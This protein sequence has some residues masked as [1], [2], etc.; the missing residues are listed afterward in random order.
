M[1][2][3]DF[4]VEDSSLDAEKLADAFFGVIKHLAQLS[5]GVGFVF[6]GGLGFD[7][8]AVGQHDDVHIDSGARVFFVGEVEQDVAV[9]DTDRGGGDHLFEGGGFQGASFDEFSE[10]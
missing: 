7:E 2:I 9:D 6:G 3:L 10:G 8:A 5:A 1:G 4:G